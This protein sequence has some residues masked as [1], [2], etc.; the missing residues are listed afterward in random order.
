MC[1]ENQKCITSSTHAMKKLIFLQI[2]ITSNFFVYVG[3]EMTWVFIIAGI[4]VYQKINSLSIFHDNFLRV[5]N[6]VQHNISAINIWLWTFK[7]SS[8]Y[9]IQ[10]R[11]L[12]YKH[13]LLMLLRLQSCLR[14]LHAFNLENGRTVLENCQK[15]VNKEGT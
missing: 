1:H 9:I 8:T 15:I 12:I 10:K 4:N 2:K 11:V 13:M 5:I 14:V 6:C 7:Q 3:S